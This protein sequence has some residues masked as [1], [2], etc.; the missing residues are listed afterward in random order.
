M[1]AGPLCPSAL[2]CMLRGEE[3]PKLMK[4]SPWVAAQHWPEKDPGQ[5]GRRR[6]AHILLLLTDLFYYS[7]TT[8][9]TFEGKRSGGQI[10]S[11][12]SWDEVGSA[13]TWLHKASSHSRP[14]SSF[15]AAPV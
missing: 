8:Q 1:R 2:A 13:P 9:G 7:F 5:G 4:L 14:L 11:R 10:Q 6:R 12:E 15:P 3:A